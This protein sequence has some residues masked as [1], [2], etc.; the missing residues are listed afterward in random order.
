VHSW[1]Y[2]RVIDN[3]QR[4]SALI[5]LSFNEVASVFE[6]AWLSIVYYQTSPFPTFESIYFYLLINGNFDYL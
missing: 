6:N 1:R 3:Y 2:R 5:R 4:H